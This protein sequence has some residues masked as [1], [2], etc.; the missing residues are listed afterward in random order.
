V[1]A[2]VP[3]RNEAEVLGRTLPSLLAQDHPNFRI[4]LV[5]D[6]STDGTGA[7]AKELAREAGREDRLLVVEGTP[8]PAGWSGKVHALH[9]GL[10]A[11]Q[12]AGPDSSW[13]LLTDADI[14]HP[15]DSVRSLLAKAWTEG[16]DLVSVMAR[17]RAVG[18]WERILIPAFVFF[19]QVLY[20]FRRASDR[21]SRVAAAAG[22]CILVRRKILEDAGAFAAI[23]G[24]I[25]DD[26]S[27]ARAVKR[28]GGDLWLGFHQEV[29]SVREYPRLADIWCMV[30]RTAFVQLRHN[31]GLL[32]LAALALLGI[33]VAP[34]ILGGLALLAGCPGAGAAALGAWAIQSMM[35]LPSVRHHRVP[36]LY[37]A[38]LPLAGLI[39]LLMTLS[40]AWDH[41][42]G[43]GPAWKGRRYG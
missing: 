6:R 43:R 23:S 18:F 7:R 37:A 28:A 14:R 39:Y 10:Q 22:G 38:V 2:I 33:V 42:R 24:E 4:I 8:T 17:L 35:L 9:I 12:A 30:S 29:V 5:D 27:L 1:A 16:R 40:S 34:P 36:A 26:V 31:Y 3:A 13:I 25:I 32:A 15:C 21:R 19:F 20:P 41:L 11:I